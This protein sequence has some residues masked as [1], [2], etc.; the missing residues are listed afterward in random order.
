MILIKIFLDCFRDNVEMP[1]SICPCHDQTMKLIG[2]YID[3]VMALHKDVKHLHIGCDEVYHLGE[4]AP[5][6]GQTRTDVFVN[7]VSNVA[8]Y[9]KSKYPQVSSQ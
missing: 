4:C 6:S 5:C 9:V 2:L 8:N 1:E 7:H 3:Q